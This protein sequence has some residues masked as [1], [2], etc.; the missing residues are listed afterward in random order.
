MKVAQILIKS[1]NLLRIENWE[2]IT[3][4]EYKGYDRKKRAALFSGGRFQFYDKG[5]SKIPA[6]EAMTSLILD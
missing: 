1:T 4:D 3:L 6:L 2:P 5:G